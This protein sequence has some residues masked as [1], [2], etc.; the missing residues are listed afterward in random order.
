MAIDY[1]KLKELREKTGVSFALCKKALEETD[2]SIEKAEKLL[3]EWGIEKAEKK[4]GREAAQGGIF[5]YVHHNRKIATMV[6]L[7]SET[8]FVSGN[9]DFQKLGKELA[10]QLAFSQTAQVE[11]F[12]KEP[13]M[14]DS[15]KSIEQLIKD[16]I[17]KFGENIK[18]ARILRWD[19]GQE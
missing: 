16:A 13:Y 8:D 11:D 4:A 14:R 1:A 10:M 19:Q 3:S 5:S 2:N 6:E 18:I 15:S 12:L 7:R 17:L 9:E